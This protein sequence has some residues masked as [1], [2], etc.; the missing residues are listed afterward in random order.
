MEA[1]TVNINVQTTAELP[2]YHA[3][4]HVDFSLAKTEHK[5]LQLSHLYWSPQEPVG[6]S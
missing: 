1:S 5:N 2:R 3:K 4:I 6:V